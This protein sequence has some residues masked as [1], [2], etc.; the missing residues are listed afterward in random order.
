MSEHLFEALLTKYKEFP[1]VSAHPIRCKK[2]FCR[3]W[4]FF[5]KTVKSKPPWG[6]HPDNK[7][8]RRYQINVLVHHPRAACPR[9]SLKITQSLQPVRPI[10][11]VTYKGT[12]FT[13]FSLIRPGALHRANGDTC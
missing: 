11:N 10:E 3:M 5:W 4:K 2:T 12:V 13:D 9:L 7:L 8:P 1:E 6:C